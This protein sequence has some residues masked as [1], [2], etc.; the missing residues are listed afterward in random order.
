MAWRWAGD[1]PLSE[2]MMIISLMQ[3]CVTRPQWVMTCLLRLPRGRYRKMT[4]FPCQRSCHVYYRNW[5]DTE[6]PFSHMSCRWSHG[7][8]MLWLLPL[9]RYRTSSGIS[10]HVCNWYLGADSGPVLTYYEV[11]NSANM[12]AILVLQHH[13]TFIVGS[14]AL[15]RDTQNCGLLMRR[16]CWER[17]PTTDFKENR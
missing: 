16:E 7:Y 4:T 17:F 9:G 6:L 3:T 8:G 14:M 11:F 15:L 12:G 2:P 10:W 5:S 13:G 1:K